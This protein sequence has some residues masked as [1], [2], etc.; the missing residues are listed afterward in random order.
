CREKT[1]ENLVKDIRYAIRSMLKTPGF[2]AIAILSLALGIG[3][4][5]AIFSLVNAILFR[6]LPIAD[7]ARVFEVTPA[8]QGSDIGNFSYPVYREVRDRNEVFDAMAIYRFAPI[9]LSREGNNE[10]IWGYILSGNYFE[11]LGV[12]PTL[13]RFFTQ[14]EDRVPG[15]NPL[16]VLSYRCWQNRFGGDPNMVGKQI[17]LNSNKFDVIGIAPEGFSGTVLIFTP[18]IWV[19]TMM[20]A[21]IEPGVRW[22]DQPHNGVVFALGRLKQGI[23]ESQ[24]SQ[25]LTYRM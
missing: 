3:A 8:R 14:E 9:S 4:N 21:Q 6:P 7:P 2:T 22:L 23:N 18:E 24:A 15:A 1:M 12:K 19:P 20:A 10:R 13:G 5:A 16:A 25:S 11:M 17:T